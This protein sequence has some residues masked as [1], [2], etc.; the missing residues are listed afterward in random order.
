MAQI[1]TLEYY[2][3]SSHEPITYSVGPHAFAWNSVLWFTAFSLLHIPSYCVI[4]ALPRGYPLRPPP[5][6]APLLTF[7]Y[8]FHQ[9]VVREP[10]WSPHHPFPCSYTSVRLGPDVR[11]ILL[12]LCLHCVHIVDLSRT[13]PFLWRV[14]CSFCY[15]MVRR[16][17]LTTTPTR[18]REKWKT[19][20]TRS[21]SYS[22]TTWST[23]ST[24]CPSLNDVTSGTADGQRI[25][26]RGQVDA[27]AGLTTIFP[28]L[29]KCLFVAGLT[30]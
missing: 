17:R 13:L 23:T 29:S 6:L 22:W 20:A 26:P 25:R 18:S 7:S 19:N 21:T 12:P 14:S 10:L 24:L 5:P 27:T 28:S 4:D 16:A 11:N 9:L 30:A 2:V 3:C 8:L 15:A 1:A